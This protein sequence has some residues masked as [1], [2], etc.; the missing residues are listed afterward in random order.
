MTFDS[1][2]EQ[3]VCSSFSFVGYPNAGKSTLLSMLSRT[4]P[5]ISP[6]PFTTLHPQVGTVIFDDG[7]SFTIAD[8]PG[9]V[10]GSHVKMG[11]GSR[12][13][14]HTLRSKILLF[15][16]DINGFQLELRSPLRSAFDSIVFLTKELELYEPSLL[17]KPAILAINKIDQ[18]EDQSKL[19][20]LYHC[21]DNYEEVLKNDYE[22]RWCPKAFFRFEHIVEIAGKHGTNCDQ[23]CSLL[24]RSLDTQADRERRSTKLSSF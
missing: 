24:R 6:V 10:E 4:K 3:S 7:R 9:L 2:L 1:N 23:L 17:R 14:K 16:I 22:E 20:E 12:F 8:L 21:L 19:Q 11:L 13:L 5:A 15:V 18:L